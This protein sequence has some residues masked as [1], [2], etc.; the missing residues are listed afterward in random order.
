MAIS[1]LKW[2]GIPPQRE[3][4]LREA[5][6][7]EIHRPNAK[8]KPPGSPIVLE[9]TVDRDRN[10]HF[11]VVWEEFENLDQEER[12]RVIYGAIKEALGEKV[13][14]KTTLILGFTPPEAEEWGLQLP[15]SA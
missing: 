1:K 10:R 3:K 9:A 11:V 15:E 8:P 5:V 7:R 12:H 13:A 6:K 2:K 14:M 4:A